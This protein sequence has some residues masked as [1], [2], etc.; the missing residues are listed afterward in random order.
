MG[1]YYTGAHAHIDQQ[2]RYSITIPFVFL[3]W[4]RKFCFELSAGGSSIGFARLFCLH[5]RSSVFVFAFAVTFAISGNAPSV[6]E[7]AVVVLSKISIQGPKTPK[8]HLIFQL[9]V[10]ARFHV[11]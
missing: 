6:G 8:F 1:N 7:V 3:I 4:M 9:E 5:S 10:V 2:C 11:E